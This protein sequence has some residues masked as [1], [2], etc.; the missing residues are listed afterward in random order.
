MTSDGIIYNPQL[1]DEAYKILLPLISDARI[2]KILHHF[3]ENRRTQAGS[4]RMIN[5]YWIHLGI[6]LHLGCGGEL[7]DFLAK[8]SP[9]DIHSMLARSREFVI[10]F[11]EIYL[12]GNDCVRNHLDGRIRSSIDQQDGFVPLDLEFT[13]SNWLERQLD[14]YVRR[15]EYLGNEKLKD[16]VRGGGDDIGFNCDFNAFSRTGWFAEVDC[17]CVFSDTGNDFSDIASL[18][19]YECLVQNIQTSRQ[20]DG[21]SDLLI[22]ISLG[23]GVNSI[24]NFNDKIEDIVREAVLDMDGVP[25]QV[26][27]EGVRFQW[28]RSPDLFD[29]ILVEDNSDDSRDASDLVYRYVLEKFGFP[30]ESVYFFD[31]R[32]DRKY[33][34]VVFAQRV[35]SSGRPGLLLRKNTLDALKKSSSKQF[36]PHGNG[37]LAISVPDLQALETED[38]LF[39]GSGSDGSVPSTLTA[40]SVLFGSKR[41]AHLAGVIFVGAL[42]WRPANLLSPYGQMLSQAERRFQVILNRSHENYED[43]KI[44]L[45][46]SC[47]LLAVKPAYNPC[48]IRTDLPNSSST[49]DLM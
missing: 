49:E 45:G 43:N 46:R 39:N 10:N 25:G 21:L 35:S 15:S 32:F 28:E 24:L 44:F 11:A 19:I 16:I 8:C 38:L 36:S 47:E 23:K 33:P 2:N 30:V 18:A 1:E 42:R 5:K 40:A 41:A 13:V 7:I 6:L 27:V 26:G 29:E 17:K 48:F 34:I 14:L 9:S 3:N 20:F 12:K 4:E 22:V 31:S 37:F